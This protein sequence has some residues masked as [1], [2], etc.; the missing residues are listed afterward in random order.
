VGSREARDAVGRWGERAASSGS[1]GG[2]NGAVELG[3]ARRGVWTALKYSREPGDDG[4]V[5]PGRSMA[6]AGEGARMDRRSKGGASGHRKACAARR[7]VA[8]RLPRRVL[9]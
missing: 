3:G 2:G 9:N 6:H 8:R 5:I 4:G 7:R 1:G